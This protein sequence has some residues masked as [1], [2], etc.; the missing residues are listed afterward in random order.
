MIGYFP[1]NDS[2]RGNVFFTDHNIYPARNSH[3]IR[4]FDGTGTP[5]EIFEQVIPSLGV[6][7]ES[8][9]R[10]FDLPTDPL[11]VPANDPRS[12]ETGLVLRVA[13]RVNGV[14]VYSSEILYDLRH[15][16][17]DVTDF[18]FVNPVVRTDPP[19]DYPAVFTDSRPT[20]PLGNYHYDV[21]RRNFHPS[22]NT[23]KVDDRT[24]GI[25]GAWQPPK[26][27]DPVN[28]FLNLPVVAGDQLFWVRPRATYKNS[29]GANIGRFD[30][31]PKSPNLNH[32][33]D[34]PPPEE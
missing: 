9:S 25:A 6:S 28:I 4:L 3:R 15:Q 22:Q 30:V 24:H 1:N 31:A 14:A 21:F 5:P 16:S 2:G 8:A 33:L 26:D 19:G 7:P 13:A 10:A 12:Y 17:A 20:G 32:A 23:T 29:N 27:H 11:E 18:S 34:I